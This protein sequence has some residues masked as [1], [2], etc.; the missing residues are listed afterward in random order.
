MSLL[1]QHHR[2][3]KEKT[4]LSRHRYKHMITIQYIDGGMLRFSSNTEKVCQT[5][6]D[7]LGEV[8]QN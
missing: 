4:G 7:F 8:A 2:C 3:I 6:E 1:G 5:G